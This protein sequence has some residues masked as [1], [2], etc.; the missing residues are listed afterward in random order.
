[1]EMKLRTV[2]LNYDMQFKYIKFFVVLS[3]YKTFF[4]FFVGQGIDFSSAP[5]GH[6]HTHTHKKT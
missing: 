6:T 2:Q 4:L 5:R 1:M 3:T